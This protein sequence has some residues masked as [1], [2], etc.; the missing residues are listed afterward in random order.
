MTDDIHPVASQESL[1]QPT[2]NI[3]K[4]TIDSPLLGIKGHGKWAQPTNKLDFN[5]DSKMIDDIYPVASQESLLQPLWQEW[6]S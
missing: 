1:L 6:G 5:L 2:R 4:N 3:F